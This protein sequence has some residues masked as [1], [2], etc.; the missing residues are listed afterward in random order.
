MSGGRSSSPQTSGA[1]VAEFRL[2]P[3]SGSLLLQCSCE[4]QTPKQES[5]G[6][7]DFQEAPRDDQQTL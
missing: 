6:E 7:P 2:P 1:A 3:A 5:I 4:R